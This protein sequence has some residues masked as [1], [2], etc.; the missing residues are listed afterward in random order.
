MYLYFRLVG[1]SGEPFNFI[2][3]ALDATIKLNGSPDVRTMEE[4]TLPYNFDIN[5]KMFPNF[6]HD[7]NIFIISRVSTSRDYTKGFL[8]P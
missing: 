3:R 4:F 7:T 6:T 5:I 2:D 8:V 1:F